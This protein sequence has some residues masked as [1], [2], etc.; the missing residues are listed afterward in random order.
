MSRPTLGLVPDSTHSV[1][2]EDVPMPQSMTMTTEML[3]LECA[4]LLNVYGPDSPEVET[5]I[6]EHSENR[7]FA[8]LA[9]FSMHVKRALLEESEQEESL[10]QMSESLGRVLKRVKHDHVCNSI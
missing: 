5:F 7:E 6:A 10:G 3:L 9:R 8:D 2:E 1:E 4:R